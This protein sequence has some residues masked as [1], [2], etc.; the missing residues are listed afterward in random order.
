MTEKNL[1]NN[2]VSITSFNKG[3]ASKIFSRLQEEKQIIV[4]KNNAPTAILLSPDEY[5]RLLTMAEKGEQ[6]Q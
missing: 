6:K 2:L 1:L 3:Q 5:D 4:L